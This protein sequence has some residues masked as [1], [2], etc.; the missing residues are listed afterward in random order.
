MRLPLVMLDR[1][2][3]SAPELR[4]RPAPLVFVV[5]PSGGAA[6]SVPGSYAA[7]A[8]TG[9]ALLA[10]ELSQRF[11]ALGAAVIPLRPE[12]G[13]AAPFHWGRWFVR[14]ARAALD[15]GSGADGA[16]GGAVDAIGYAGAGAMALLRDESLDALLSPVAGEVVAN[17]RFSADAF[18]V[19]FGE[20]GAAEVLAALDGCPTDN[21]APRA[22]ETAGFAVRDISAAPFSRFDV[23]T[24]L[25][26]AL[27]RLATRL[28]GSRALDGRVA[29][30]L[31]MAALPGGRSLEVPLLAELGAVIRDRDAE[32]VI[33]GR[34]P[35]A[36]WQYLESETACR[37]RAFVEERGMRSARAAR[38]RSLLAR[39]V[40]EHGPAGLIAELATLGDGVVLDS[41]VLMAALSGSS[42]AAAW[43]D[44][45]ERFASDFGDAGRITTSWLAELTAAAAAASVPILMGGHALVSDGL[46]LIVAA[47]WQGR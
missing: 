11:G 46:R 23:D 5:D 25:D 22:L 14:A 37:I 17:N 38:P 20:G 33:A 32:L 28:D 18:V 21:A 13:G 10:G 36:T 6:A 31:E 30:L 26:L 12:A 7:V 9:Q 35:A 24:P 27:L 15:D 47:A 29:G 34:I 45:E 2:D 8:A 3:A 44:E 42:D 16:G 40:E 1:T 39:W 19:A 4:G 41:R 43:P